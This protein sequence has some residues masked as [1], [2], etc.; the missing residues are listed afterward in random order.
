MGKI[1]SSL[2]ITAALAALSV[3]AQAVGADGGSDMQVPLG[4]SLV[5]VLGACGGVAG[6]F[7]LL[8][9]RR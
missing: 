6:V 3:T 1:R 5:G 4:P 9:R 7:A 2:A 8:L